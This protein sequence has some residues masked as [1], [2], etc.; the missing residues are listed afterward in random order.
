MPA[1]TVLATPWSPRILVAGI[2]RGERCS[3]GRAPEVRTTRHP[4]LDAL[5]YCPSPSRQSR[6][7]S[8]TIATATATEIAGTSATGI[9]KVSTRRSQVG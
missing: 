4:Q 6:V 3:R 9:T 1:P 5:V 2:R 7:E 8:Q